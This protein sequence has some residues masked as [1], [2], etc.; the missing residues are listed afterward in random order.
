MPAEI[1][2]TNE[3]LND[4]T[5]NPQNEQW[6]P[7]A[8]A[9]DYEVSNHGRLRRG[10]RL[11]AGYRLRNGY[12]GCSVSQDGARRS[13]TIHALVAEAFI[14]N[15]EG[16]PEVNHK[17]GVKDDNQAENLE[18]VTHSENIRHSYDVL[19]NKGRPKK[20]RKPVDTSPICTMKLTMRGEA[21]CFMEAYPGNRPGNLRVLLNGVH[22]PKLDTT[23][24]LMRWL[25]RKMP[26]TSAKRATEA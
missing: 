3:A 11:I 2:R 26:R 6:L 22:E 21:D 19:G 1:Y 17:N 7:V 13:T 8:C 12:V 4:M 25:R 18:W 23:T 9:P 15:P 14:P 5:A 10:E 16:K 20:P 24:E